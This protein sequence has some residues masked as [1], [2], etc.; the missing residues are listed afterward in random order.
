MHLSRKSWRLEPRSNHARCRQQQRAARDEAVD[1]ALRWGRVIR[2]SH[3][4]TAYFLGKKC[5]QQAARAGECIERFIGTAV[6]Q[7]ADSTI[8]TVIRSRDSRRLR[9]WAR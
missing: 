9:R 6:V 8:V 5:A 4:R 7:A 1:A 2:Q 3:C